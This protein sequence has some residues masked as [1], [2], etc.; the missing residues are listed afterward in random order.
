MVMAMV[1]ATGMAMVMVEPIVPRDKESVSGDEIRPMKKLLPI[2]L[3][4][5]L[6]ACSADR[7]YH[8]TVN[9]DVSGEVFPES[10][11]AIA[12]WNEQLEGCV[13]L[14]IGGNQDDAV[15]IQE[16]CDATT[17]LETGHYNFKTRV[18]NLCRAKSAPIGMTQ[19]TLRHEI[20]HVL[21]QQDHVDRD[22]CL[23][24]GTSASWDYKACEETLKKIRVRWCP[25]SNRN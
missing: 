6:M 24:S 2:L 9:F 16:D 15:L 14:S 7:P 5:G 18:I 21:G 17:E 25:D 13:E 4:L 19:K 8:H 10:V 3:L 23:M 1:M 22:D 11:A 20:G 12:W